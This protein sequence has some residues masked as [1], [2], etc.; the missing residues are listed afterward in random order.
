MSKLTIMVYLRFITDVELGVDHIYFDTIRRK[1]ILFVS[2]WNFNQLTVFELLLIIKS[3]MSAVDIIVQFDNE[4]L[5]LIVYEDDFDLEHFERWIRSRF[6]INLNDRI[7]YRNKDDKGMWWSLEIIHSTHISFMYVFI[8]NTCSHSFIFSFIH[9]ACIILIWTLFDL[10]TR[11]LT[12]ECLPSKT[13]FKTNIFI[14]V[15]RINQSKSNSSNIDNSHCSKVDLSVKSKSNTDNISWYFYLAPMGWIILLSIVYNLKYNPK[16]SIQLVKHL[17]VI[18]DILT[19]YGIVIKRDLMIDSFIGFV[20]WPVTYMFI[21]RWLNP[22]SRNDCFQKYN[23]DTF[24]GGL[25]A[26]CNVVLRSV[27]LGCIQSPN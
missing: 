11:S 24:F 26:A 13:F 15:E 22:Q 25:A 27:L 18:E 5:N 1:L 14:R 8:I 23:Q 6:I 19:N 9:H 16:L 2:E 21:R 17:R 3:I 20:T 12:L 7:I 10:L 4:Q